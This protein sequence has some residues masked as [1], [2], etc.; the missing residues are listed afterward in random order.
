MTW[1]RLR[2]TSLLLLLATIICSVSVGYVE[3]EAEPAHA[4]RDQV[5]QNGAD[6][7]PSAT[8]SSF[9]FDGHASNTGSVDDTNASIH[10]ATD[11]RTDLGHE[12]SGSGHEASG[13]GHEAAK[14]SHKGPTFMTF[15]GPAAAGV[16]AIVL[17]GCVIVFK[18]RKNK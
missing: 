10:A 13:S 5:Q 9:E 3:A 15:L 17:I 6:L 12:A 2:I 8:T 16:L 11:P 18:N 4:I 1:C 14:P 7:H